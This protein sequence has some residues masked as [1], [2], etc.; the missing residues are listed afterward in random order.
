MLLFVSLLQLLSCRTP[1]R[2]DERSAVAAGWVRSDRRD[3]CC[4]LLREFA[5]A[6]C[7][8]LPSCKA[9]RDRFSVLFGDFAGASPFT[10]ECRDRRD[11]FRARSGESVAASSPL[12]FP[13]AYTDRRDWCWVLFSESR[14]GGCC[15]EGGTQALMELH[16]VSAIVALPLGTSRRRVGEEGRLGEEVLLDAVADPVVVAVL[17]VLDGDLGRRLLASLRMLRVDGRRFGEMDRLW[18]S[19][20][21]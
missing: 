12:Q 4:A 19:S 6:F 13:A 10:L 5:E 18:W 15:D 9:R 1:E 21:S 3:R 11:R 14:E 17:A 7:P 8:T 20:M 2:L 16:L